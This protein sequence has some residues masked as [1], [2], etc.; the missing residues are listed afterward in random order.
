MT[1]IYSTMNTH[2]Y[3][4]TFCSIQIP[5]SINQ[6]IRTSTVPFH[7]SFQ[8]ATLQKIKGNASTC[9]KSGFTNP[10][11]HRFFTCLTE[12]GFTSTKHLYEEY[13]SFL[14]AKECT[15][16]LEE[17]SLTRFASFIARKYQGRKLRFI[18]SVAT[19]CKYRFESM[20]L[21]QP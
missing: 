18:P 15:S 5:K 3:I 4:V 10:F 14:V 17:P 7:Y 1:N 6:S 21:K 19:S 8:N 9:E 12:E 11:L 2:P 13:T 20:F 16:T